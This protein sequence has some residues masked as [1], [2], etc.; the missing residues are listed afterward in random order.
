MKEQAELNK[1]TIPAAAST[2]AT[3]LSEALERR[4]KQLYDE[5]KAAKTSSKDEIEREDKLRLMRDLFSLEFGGSFA[6]SEQVFPAFYAQDLI[7]F[8]LEHDIVEAVRLGEKVMSENGYTLSLEMQQAVKDYTLANAARY[9]KAM[10]RTGPIDNSTLYRRQRGQEKPV[11]M[12]MDDPYWEEF[13]KKNSARTQQWR[14]PS[15]IAW[16]HKPHGIL[17]DVYDFK[18]VQDSL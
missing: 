7:T 10:S 4:V 13:V 3:P 1:D 15:H 8:G 12:S 11:I 6:S 2:R 9:H 17:S 5:Y 16:E 14:V 18:H